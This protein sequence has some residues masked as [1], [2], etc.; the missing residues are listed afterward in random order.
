M[1]KMKKRSIELNCGQQLLKLEVFQGK[2]TDNV[3]LCGPGRVISTD[4]LLRAV[5]HFLI[6][7]TTVLLQD[8]FRIIDVCVCICVLSLTLL[9]A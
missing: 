8:C 2:V 6:T 3:C 7:T 4:L 5:R 1:N 9:K